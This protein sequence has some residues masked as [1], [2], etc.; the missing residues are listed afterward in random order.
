M[1]TPI[2]DFVKKYANSEVLRLHMPGHKGNSVLG[3]EK[4]DITEIEGADVLY[5]ADGIIKESEENVARLFGTAKTLYSTEGSSLVIRTMLYLVKVCGAEKGRKPLIFA[6]RNAH[7]TF[8]TACGILDIDVT[9][10][11]PSNTETVISCNIT[12]E[13]LDASLSAAVDKPVA[14]YVTSPDYL[15]NML[16]IGVLAEV[17]HKYGAL[18]LVDNAHGAY[19][20]FLPESCHP[21]ALGADLCCDSAH[22]TLP[23]LTGGAYLH[24]AASAPKRIFEGAENAMSLFASTSPSYLILQSLDMVNKYLSDGYAEKLAD[25]IGLVEELKKELKNKGYRL[26]GNEPLKIAVAPKAYGYSG[27]ELAKILEKEKIICEFADPDFTV[28][29]LTPETGA[30]GVARL[31]KA[32]LSIEKQEAKPEFMP[33]LSSKQKRMSIKEAIFSSSVEI[34]TDKCLGRILSAPT[35]SCPPAIPIVI[36]GEEIDR[37][38]VEC[39]KYYG[40]KK[41]SVVEDTHYI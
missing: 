4:L 22:K 40:I 32:L 24:I 30:A 12:P 7:K 31:K 5:K 3:I 16:D 36:C 15:G 27:Y 8:V 6:G 28:L 2:V 26:Y 10:L 11:T 23:V 35:V 13:F 14:V 37:N 18:L 1:T 38:A 17:C 41:C 34:D 20:N 9:W 25:F 19:L 33:V 39:F 29:M 21:I